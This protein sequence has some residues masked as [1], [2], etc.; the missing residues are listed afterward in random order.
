MPTDIRLL[1]AMAVL[2]WLALMLSS[3]LRHRLWTPGG[4]IVGA[5]NRDAVPEPS[6]VAARADRAAKNMLENLLL[7]GV[8]L[9]SAHAAGVHDDRL[10]LGTQ[11]F[12]VGRVAYL[13]TYVLGVR[14]LRT[15]WW[16]VGVV[17][18][19]IV[20]SALL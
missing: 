20:A 6:P 15:L 2:N 1:V 9:L 12:C 4:W 3:T 17:G 11:V 5:G 7:F 19:G 18:M 14:Y 13:P 8:T 10:L 16:A